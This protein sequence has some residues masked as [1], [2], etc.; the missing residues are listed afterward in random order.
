[1]FVG[2]SESGKSTFLKQLKIAS[3][4]LSDGDR[5]AH[6]KA[7]YKTTLITVQTTLQQLAPDAELENPETKVYKLVNKHYNS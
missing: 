2:V 1:V 7:I 5:K 6:K 4:G 3:G